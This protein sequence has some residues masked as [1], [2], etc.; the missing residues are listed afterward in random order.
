MS[1][2][3]IAEGGLLKGL[4]LSLEG[5]EQWT[6]GRNP[7]ECQL[8]IEDPEVSSKHA[9][10]RKVP[11]GIVLENLS[12]N[13]PVLLNGQELKEP[14]LIQE[15]DKVKIG[16]EV[17]RYQIN[18][19]AIAPAPENAVKIKTADV[20]AQIKKEVQDEL[21]EESISD[22]EEQEVEVG[23][24]A[25]SSQTQSPINSKPNSSEDTT[26]PNKN[27]AHEHETEEHRQEQEEQLPHEEPAEQENVP[28]E[29]EIQQGEIS[30]DTIEHEVTDVGPSD[31]P[32]QEEQIEHEKAEA[33]PSELY[34]EAE[35]PIKPQSFEEIKTPSEEPETIEEQ[36]SKPI[37]EG[38]LP[39][40][41]PMTATQELE[42]HENEEIIGDIPEDTLFEDDN[43]LAEIDFD[44][45]DSG[46][47]M[48]KVVGGANNGAEFSL[49][50]SSTYTIGTDPNSCDIVFYDTS[51]S[52]T[53]A[54][55]TIDDQE[56]LF[57]EDLKS[58]NG[59]LVDGEPLTE[60][61]PL[62]TNVIV[63]MGTTSFVVLDREGEMH[64][65]IS[66]L[67]PSI[68]KVLQKEE[69]SK[70]VEEVAAAESANLAPA[71]TTPLPPK[72]E[73]SAHALNAFIL[74]SIITGLFVLAG[75][76]I[77][78]L[79]QSK[80]IEVH[81]IENTD[82]QLN[83]ALMMFP[84]VKHS[85][86]KSTGRLLLVGHVLTSVDKNQLLYNLQGLS[87]IKSLDDSGIVIDEY[88]WKEINQV[89]TKNPLW[90]GVT[91]H[92][93]TA[94]HFVLSGYL[95]TRKQAEQL[96]DYLSSNFP[97]LDLLEKKVIVEED[98]ANAAM[99][100]LQNKGI[101]DVKVEMK[102]GQLILTGTV[103]KENLKAYD[104]LAIEFSKIPGVR[105][106][107]NLVA[108][109]APTS[110]IENISDR[111][112]VT[113]MSNQ[114][115]AISVV[116]K[117]RILQVNDVIDGMTIKEITPHSIFLERDGRKYKI[118]F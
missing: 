32:K 85:F 45:Q 27:E 37:E 96:S 68:V 47:W 12:P 3:L 92:A 73:S 18:S 1:A 91:V 50:P 115:K 34:S 9:V 66:P 30:P 35:N 110:A 104:E 98:V 88:V 97:Y 103:N 93:P 7:K 10:C 78:T 80:P 70:K 25:T 41:G 72:E 77:A 28:E 6:I 46:R 13:N 15:G 36:P 16:S 33:L 65:I 86:N 99:V 58:R 95:K 20:I 26:E 89:L 54:R 69:E 24:E 94:G 102:E 61:C 60:K 74:I 64:T 57:I 11:E 48:L 71:P 82:A 105:S 101:R 39:K 107:Q 76:G 62:E 43:S 87:F 14:T 108:Q 90:K 17:F 106:I 83:E 79:F 52:R 111:Y 84:G 21:S 116:I 109:R 8:L 22:V 5:A 112:Q 29:S 40:E 53:H 2:K 118:D 44:L 113:G 100:Q 31:Q 42:K 38:Q 81:Q 23:D 19:D 75:L 117:G 49:H 4:V 114:G 63:T 51:V 56:H 67:L 55:I 59:T